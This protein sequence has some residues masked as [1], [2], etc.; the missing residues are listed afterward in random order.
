ME[1]PG[2][3]GL[4]DRTHDKTTHR[5]TAWILVSESQVQ[6]VESFSVV[7]DTLVASPAHVPVITWTEGAIE[8]SHQG[9]AIASARAKKDRHDPALIRRA[10]KDRHDPALIQLSPFGP[11]ATPR[12]E[13]P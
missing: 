7:G 10:K 1:L 8:V 4:V 12:R 2:E 9:I 6:F 13:R 5:V 11:R 3:D